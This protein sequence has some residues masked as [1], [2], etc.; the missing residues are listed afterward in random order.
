MILKAIK[1]I[2]IIFDATPRQGDFFALIARYI[3]LDSD[4]KR[5]VAEQQLIH[6]AA[7][8][9]SLNQYS[10]VGEVSRGL[11]ARGIK[12]DQ[13]VVDMQDGCSTNGAAHDMM[14]RIAAASNETE[15]LVS[16]CLSHC[17]SNAGESILCLV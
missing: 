7:I 6:C 15:R 16:T 12:N 17:A 2:G 10:Q 13:A 5:A 9:G 4:K 3:V 14:N 1:Y 11:Q 8:N